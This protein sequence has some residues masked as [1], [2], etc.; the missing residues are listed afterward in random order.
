[1]FFAT[2]ITWTFKNLILL[3]QCLLFWSSVPHI[4][5]S[6][7]KFLGSQLLSFGQNLTFNFRS[8]RRD[9]RLS[10]ED[11]VLEGAGLRVTV[12]LIAQGNAYPE[13]NYKTYVFRWAFICS[14]F[15]LFFF[16]FFFLLNSNFQ[17][18]NDQSAW[19]GLLMFA[20]LR[21]GKNISQSLCGQTSLPFFPTA[22]EQF[23]GSKRYSHKS[24]EAWCP[25]VWLSLL[26][27]KKKKIYDCCPKFLFTESVL[28]SWSFL[29]RVGKTGHCFW[30]KWCPDV[31]CVVPGFTTPLTTRGGPTSALVTSRNFYTTW[32]PSKSVAPTVREVCLRWCFAIW[33]YTTTWSILALC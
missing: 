15:C 32:R 1:M 21:D 8:D 20:G 23:L 31:R 29:K 5:V 33:Y 17:T 30:L 24:V 4:C 6:I 13:E 26:R 14:A 18:R 27:F 19:L 11:V 2:L 16:F 22:W 25:G 12:P 7:E 10:A 3:L 28:W 9:T